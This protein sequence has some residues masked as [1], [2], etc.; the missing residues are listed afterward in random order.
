MRYL[1][2]GVHQPPPLRHPMHQFVVEEEG[3]SRSRLL[4]VNVHAGE[5]DTFLFHV[6]GPPERYEAELLDVSRIE[7]YELSPRPDGSFYLYV[8]ERV[9][10][11]GR[12]FA[13]A[14]DRPGI[15]VVTPVDYRVDGTVR[16]TLVGPAGALQ[17]ALAETPDG[18]DVEVLALGEYDARRFDAGGGLTDRQFEAVTAAV[19]CG[20]YATPRRGSVAEVG[21]RLGCS[22]SA[23]AELLRRA[24]KRVMGQLIDGLS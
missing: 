23:A 15:L 11:H 22:P 7:T 17:D 21:E 9:S 19:D 6:D 8:R 16:L 3:Y 13:G 10:E 14:F 5:V 2:V 4:H 24:E 18:M 1:E 12:Q 20:Y